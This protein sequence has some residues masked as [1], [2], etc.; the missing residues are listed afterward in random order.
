M[1]SIDRNGDDQ[2]DFAEF[3]NAIRADPPGHQHNAMVLNEP[4]SP[5]DGHQHTVFEFFNELMPMSMS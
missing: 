3:I 4:P 1:K 2:V 5:P